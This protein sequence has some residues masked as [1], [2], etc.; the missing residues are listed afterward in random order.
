MN[1]SSGVCT[2]G[3]SRLGYDCSIVTCPGG[4]TCNSHGR[5]IEGTVNHCECNDGWVGDDCGTAVCPNDCNGHGECNPNSIPPSC[6]CVPPWSG[7]DCSVDETT[8]QQKPDTI[9]GVG[10]VVG[11]PITYEWG[12]II[13]VGLA[14][15]IVSI[16]VTTY[17]I[18]RRKQDKLRFSSK[19]S[20]SDFELQPQNS[21]SIAEDH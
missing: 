11:I 16:S 6:N 2:C 20:S 13:L 5:C 14:A 21:T 12:A 10:S 3:S 18:I 7:T 17:C 1:C 15:I 9:L 8:Q 4:P 19:K